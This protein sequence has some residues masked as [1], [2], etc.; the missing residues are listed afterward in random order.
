M[1]EC[2]NQFQAGREAAMAGRKRDARRSADW[3]EGWDQVA[4]DFA[5]IRDG[6]SNSTGDE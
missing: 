1:A 3:L 6:N 4:S 2:I 5:L